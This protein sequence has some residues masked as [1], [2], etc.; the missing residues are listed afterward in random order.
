MLPNLAA[1]RI[2]VAPESG[3]LHTGCRMNPRGKCIP[4]SCM[5]E[6]RQRASGI[7]PFA[8]NLPDEPGCALIIQR[9]PSRQ[10]SAIRFFRPALAVLAC[11]E[12]PRWP[13][14]VFTQ[15]AAKSLADAIE[16]RPDELMDSGRQAIALPHQCPQLPQL[17]ESER[18]HAHGMAVGSD[19]RMPPF[20]RS[21]RK[22]R[23]RH[24]SGL[25]H[26]LS[27]SRQHEADCPIRKS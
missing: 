25:F 9:I 11:A 10:R 5:D 16:V 1:D 19:K 15:Q 20:K 4:D 13:A 14:E 21:R 6:A 27:Y 12:N 26:W 3:V 7:F 23:L 22:K 17:P 18:G 2:L 8:H 24:C